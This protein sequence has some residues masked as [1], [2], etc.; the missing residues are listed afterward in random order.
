MQSFE[1]TP[2][3]ARELLP[4]RIRDLGL[5]LE[6]SM[7]EKYVQQLHAELAAKGLE[8]FRPAVYLSDE[9]A[10]PDREPIIGAPFYLADPKVAALERAVNDLEDEREILMYLRHEAGHAFNYAYMLYETKEWLD[11][12][13]P[14]DRPYLD[15][16]KPVPFSRKYVRHIA[17]WYAQK[18]PDEDFA[19]TFAVWLTP[20]S[21]WQRRYGGWAALKKLKYVD[22]TAK[23]LATTPPRKALEVATREMPV[24]EMGSTIEQ[25]YKE[26]AELPE[27]PDVPDSELE[28]IFVRKGVDLRPASAFL[29]EHRKAIV[30]K[31]TYWTGVRR[32]I[33]RQLMETIGR[34]ARELELCVERTR[35]QQT[36]IEV[37][38]F[39][40][41]LAMNYLTR[42]GFTER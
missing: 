12:F 40:T 9:W 15:E 7:L 19:E 29:L 27:L 5:R 42:G 30:D 3:E 23:A 4:R 37:V 31:I 41:T 24:E 18:H 22:R 13:G 16:Y 38:A 21:D 2:P 35:E 17:G 1:Q 34:R 36:L 25:F 6:G 39:A 20:D 11:L 8:R 10:C 28:D 26:H 14:F 32:P 33:V